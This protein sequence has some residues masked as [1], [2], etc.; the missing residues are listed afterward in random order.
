LEH[1]KD[2]SMNSEQ[3]KVLQK[4]TQ[5]T[6]TSLKTLSDTLVREAAVDGNRTDL[7]EM[8]DDAKN[9]NKVRILQR[10]EVEVSD[11][12]KRMKD[13]LNKLRIIRS[14]FRVGHIAMGTMLADAMV[15]N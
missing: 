2:I 8:L 7:V 15:K 3:Y 10:K 9:N 6:E 12:Q 13:E 5:I 4:M 1:C 11:E 14:V